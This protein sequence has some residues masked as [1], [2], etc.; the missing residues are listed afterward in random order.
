MGV[1]RKSSFSCRSRKGVRNDGKCVVM[2]KGVTC[3]YVYSRD[4][5][6]REVV[7]NMMKI[8]NNTLNIQKTVFNQ[9]F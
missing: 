7:L 4:I 8:F 5:A 2:L 6:R 1:R 9:E 3:K